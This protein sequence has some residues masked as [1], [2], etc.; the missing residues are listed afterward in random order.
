[1]RRMRAEEEEA[2]WERVHS[3]TRSSMADLGREPRSEA[4][5]QRKLRV[6][7]NLAASVDLV[8]ELN[9]AGVPALNVGELGNVRVQYER[10]IPILIRHL[11]RTYPEGVT[12]SIIRALAVPYGGEMAFRAVLS[13]YSRMRQN[14]TRLLAE[15]FGVAFGALLTKEHLHEG[16]I[17]ARDSLLAGGRVFVLLRLAKLHDSD[18]VPIAESYLGDSAM[19]PVAVRS[20]RLLKAWNA[21]PNI[22][23]LMLSDNLEVRKEA[24]KFFQAMSKTTNERGTR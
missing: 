14:L 6:R 3:W 1:M 5:L 16:R 11:D 21:W 17:L 4:D 2:E 18:S 13:T 15:D 12:G 23:P 24:K 7:E 19:Q 22:E 20:L 9:A 10:A 8:A